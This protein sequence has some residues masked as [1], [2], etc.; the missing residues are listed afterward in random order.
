MEGPG[1]GSEEER[2]EGLMQRPGKEG[3]RVWTEKPSGPQVRVNPP[4]PPPP[5]QADEQ[6]KN[7]HKCQQ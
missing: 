3:I 5:T 6:L 7:R 2:P 1:Q 4:P